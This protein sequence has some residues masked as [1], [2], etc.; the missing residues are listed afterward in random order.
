M[1]L[2]THEM[3][4]PHICV[5]VKDLLMRERTGVEFVVRKTI[6]LCQL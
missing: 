6:Q 4:L 1:R 5:V 2:R 3:I